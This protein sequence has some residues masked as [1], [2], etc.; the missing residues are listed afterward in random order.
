MSNKVNALSS[1]KPGVADEGE[2]LSQE[3]LSQEEQRRAE[4]NTISAAVLLEM[5]GRLTTV[6]AYRTPCLC[7]C[8]S[9]V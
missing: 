6:S 3:P 2:E 7:S 4:L 1:W 5:K 8:R 9:V